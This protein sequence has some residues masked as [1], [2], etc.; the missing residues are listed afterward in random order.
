[1]GR[2]R[3]DHG[4]DG[5]AKIALL[6]AGG[7]GADRI[8]AELGVSTATAKRRMREIK[9]VVT[10]VKAEGRQARRSAA[11]APRP[12]P[13]APSPALPAVLPSTD[14]DED[15]DISIPDGSSLEQIDRW[16]KVA[17]DEAEA[18]AGDEDP[19]NHIKWVRL[20]TALIEAKRKASPIPKP[21]PNEHP[22]MIAAAARVRKRW[23]DLANNLVR[24]SKSPLVETIGKLLRPE[25][26]PEA[27]E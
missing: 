16:L 22:D 17:E 9:G 15:A 25:P 27:K 12:A 1:M 7:H 26:E 8:A 11:R 21:D 19:D 13:I 18:A 10:E 4:T 6:M 3:I 24:V 5:Q 20:A 23:H 2:K 14:G